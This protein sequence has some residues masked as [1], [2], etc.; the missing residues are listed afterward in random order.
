MHSLFIHHSPRQRHT[1][2]AARN[3]SRPTKSEDPDGRMTEFLR[4]SSECGE[5]KCY[6]RLVVGVEVGAV[7]AGGVGLGGL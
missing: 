6:F 1:S 7:V 5:G 2:R 3:P 4:G